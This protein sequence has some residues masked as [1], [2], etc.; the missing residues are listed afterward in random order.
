LH[1]LLTITGDNAGNNGTICDALYTALLK[2][3]D[4]EDD[5]FRIKPPDAVPWPEELLWLMSST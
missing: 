4:D 1:I 2:A 3:Y 5:V